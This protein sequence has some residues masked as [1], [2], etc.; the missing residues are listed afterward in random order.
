MGF[1][2]VIIHIYRYYRVYNLLPYLVFGPIIYNQAWTMASSEG[3]LLQAARRRNVPCWFSTSKS[4][5]DR[6]LGDGDGGRMG[7]LVW[8]MEGGPGVKVWSFHMAER[9]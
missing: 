7:W 8:K 6:K 5:G 4:S 1:P 3:N 2:G 9:Q